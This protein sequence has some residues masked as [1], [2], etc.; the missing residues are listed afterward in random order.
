[1]ESVCELNKVKRGKIKADAK[2]KIKALNVGILLFS[3]D[4]KNKDI[5]VK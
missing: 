5:K 2:I 3:N 4:K 1:M